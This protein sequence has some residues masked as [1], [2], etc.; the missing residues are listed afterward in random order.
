MATWTRHG[1][2]GEDMETWKKTWNHRGGH[3]DMDENMET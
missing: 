3:G 1:N 2:M